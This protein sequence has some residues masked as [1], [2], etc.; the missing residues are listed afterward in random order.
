M[1]GKLILLVVKSI[2]ART[3]ALHIDIVVNLVD[4]VVDLSLVSRVHVYLWFNLLFLVLGALL[5]DTLCLGFY[6]IAS[7]RGFGLNCVLTL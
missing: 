1:I 2:V 7:I 5:G 3:H 4:L 6:Y